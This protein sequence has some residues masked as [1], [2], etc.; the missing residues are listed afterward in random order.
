MQIV[1][2][3]I[4]GNFNGSRR[5]NI[6]PRGHRRNVSQDTCMWAGDHHMNGLVA[7]AYIHENR[8]NKEIA[9]KCVQRP[10]MLP[11]NSD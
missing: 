6:C 5:H 2:Q 3:D 10:D 4:L 11:R 8:W 9:E 7:A 1:G